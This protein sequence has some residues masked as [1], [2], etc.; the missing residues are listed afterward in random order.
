MP[1]LQMAFPVLFFVELICFQL[2]FI[3]IPDDVTMSLDSRSRN[4]IR[5]YVPKKSEF[6]PVFQSSYNT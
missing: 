3:C 5:M 4:K 1:D 2:V 6:W